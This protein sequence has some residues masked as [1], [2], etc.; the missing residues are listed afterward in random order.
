MILLIDPTGATPTILYVKPTEDTQCP[1][2]PCHT[3]EWYAQNKTHSNTIMSFLPG[4]HN[5]T[6][7]YVASHISNLTLVATWTDDVIVNCLH[8]QSWSGMAFKNISNLT[9]KG[10][11]FFQCNVVDAKYYWQGALV[12]LNINNLRM[13]QVI[14][15]AFPIGGMC[16]TNLF[17]N[18]V[19][20][21]V[22]ID[23]TGGKST[24]LQDSIAMQIVYDNNPVPLSNFSMI[25][26]AQSTFRHVTTT[27]SLSMVQKHRYIIPMSVAF[28][29]ISFV[30][31]SLKGELGI[32]TGMGVVSLL[33]IDNVTF[34]DCDFIGNEG[35]PAI[36]AENSDF[37]LSGTTIFRNNTANEGGA[38]KFY[39]NSHIILSNNSNIVFENNTA[40]HAGGA[41]FVTTTSNDDHCFFELQYRQPP[42]CDYD[43]FRTYNI[44][45]SFINNTA[46]T[47]GGDAI[48]GASL[49]TCK[50]T[51]RQVLDGCQGWELLKYIDFKPSMDSDL[52]LISSDPTRICL[53]NS[54]KTVNCTIVFPTF[55]QAYYPGE[56][57]YIPA[58]VVG[59]MF[60]TVDGA[61]YAH[62]LTQG[63]SGVF[64]EDL[65]QVQHV[66]HNRCTNLKYSI[67]TDPGMVVLVLTVNDVIIQRYP[68]EFE[69]YN[70]QIDIDKYEDYGQI[71]P[72]LLSTPIYI[73][74][75]LLPCP[76]GFTL[77]S[78][79]SKCV[80]DPQLRHNNIAC[81]ITDQSIYRSGTVWV[82]ASFDGNTS[83]G[84]IIS[85]YCPYNYCKLEMVAVNLEYPDSQCAFNHSG[86]ICGA[87]Q[88]G[89]SLTLGHSQCLRCSNEHLALLIP[90]AIAGLALVF[91]IKA[92]NLTV[93]VGSMNSL[94]FYANIIRASD[95]IFFPAGDTNLLTIF[96]AWLNLDL[97]IETCF[98]DGLNGYWK[99][100]LQFVFPLYIWSIIILIIILSHRYTAVA[101]IF[102]NNSVPVLATLILLSYAKLLRTIITVLAFTFLELPHGSRR[103]V[104]SF[105]GNIRYLSPVHVP[106]FLVAVGVLLFLWL[107]YTALLVSTQGIHR[108]TSYR[109]RQWMLKLKP[110][111][112]A[113]FAPM[114]HK[115]CYWVG[116]LLLVRGILFLVFAVTPT[117]SSNIDLL[118]TVITVCV[119]VGYLAYTGRVYQKRY[120]TLLEIFDFVNLGVLAAGTLYV[121]STNG[122]QAAPV[123]TCVGL[124]FVQFM[125]ILL[126]H[127]FTAMKPYCPWTGGAHGRPDRAE[128][129]DLSISQDDGEENGFNPDNQSNSSGDFREPLLKY[130]EVN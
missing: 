115:H 61:V 39:L 108:M 6:T 86:I 96:I 38:I 2:E 27:I 84:V 18:C 77:S 79:P 111:L 102:G 17:G 90:F 117:N 49:Y 43:Q 80:C 4:T 122:D 10:L 28:K 94:I 58:V 33:N 121:R 83:N 87:C 112:D 32:Y 26:I 76:L 60:G 51:K 13:F 36:Y 57:F 107:P 97:G 113:Y 120:L 69:I 85:K 48:Y 72:Y 106:L 128:Y 78:S 35:P 29:N 62:L 68:S 125:G 116:V 54:D 74:I 99:T 95:S 30:N 31:V 53:C 129:Q 81:N 56:E 92:L 88:P 8:I 47:G 19:F 103:A 24:R 42:D 123:Y 7:D 93:A 40:V 5:L 20:E 124:V 73:N 9:I 91:F 52:S 37:T 98:F 100:W 109:V 89:L 50:A 65:Q 34:I 12:F 46:K 114:K 41:V 11:T 15:Q 1:G 104:W 71:D 45:I 23:G 130:A 126:F 14:L 105:D 101:K 55:E 22:H 75:T 70:I 44:S 63:G 3:L 21:E 59:D 16:A 119:L 110:F 67:L 66:T 25:S 127:T 64:G 118:A 82:K